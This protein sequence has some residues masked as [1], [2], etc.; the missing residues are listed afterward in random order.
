MVSVIFA[1][2]RR[3][4]DPESIEERPCHRRHR[5]G[6]S[7]WAPVRD[8][9]ASGLVIGAAWPVLAQVVD[10]P[11]EGAPPIVLDAP[12]DRDGWTTASYTPLDWRHYIGAKASSSGIREATAQSGSTCLLP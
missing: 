10:R 1:V 6:I 4:S 8:G 12:A 9:I 3:W 5:R 7:G 2:G 11:R